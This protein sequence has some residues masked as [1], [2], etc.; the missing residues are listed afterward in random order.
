MEDPGIDPGTSRM[1]SE[2]STIWA[3]PPLQFPPLPYLVVGRDSL[4]FRRQRLDK[5]CQPDL[6]RL[7]IYSLLRLY[8][9]NVGTS[10]LWP[11]SP[12][13]F[14]FLRAACFG[15]LKTCAPRR[16]IEPR[17]PAWQAG[18]LTT[19][20]PRTDRFMDGIVKK[21][22]RASEL[23]RKNIFRRQLSFCSQDELK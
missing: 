15:T 22:Q 12:F 9:G 3:S 23:I 16:G 2:R 4:F 21:I 5:K 1:L 8:D 14:S 17:S 18:I 7:S 13:T 20:L 10:F 19:I 11:T 6:G